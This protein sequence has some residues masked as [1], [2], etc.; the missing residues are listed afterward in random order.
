MAP[1]N[2]LSNFKCGSS[3]SGFREDELARAKNPEPKDLRW[4]QLVV[5]TVSSGGD[6]VVASFVQL[7]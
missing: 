4:W 2:V 1:E 6:L 5:M 3:R 7:H